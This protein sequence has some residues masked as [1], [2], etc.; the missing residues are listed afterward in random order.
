MVIHALFDLFIKICEEQQHK[1][2]MK[3][4][5][6]FALKDLTKEEKDKIKKDKKEEQKKGETLENK[7]VKNLKK[8]KESQSKFK[9][10]KFQRKTYK[11]IV[12]YRSR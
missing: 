6:K 3:Q 1:T 8:T 12:F 7:D 9:Y 2:K 11:E 4:N 5:G 10:T